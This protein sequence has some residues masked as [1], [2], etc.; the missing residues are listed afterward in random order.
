MVATLWSLVGMVGLVVAIV[1]LI[2]RHLDW[3][4]PANSKAAAAFG[5]SLT[6]LVLG[7]CTT[8]THPAHATRLEAVAVASATPS[9]EL[10]DPVTIMGGDPDEAQPTSTTAASTAGLS[11]AAALSPSSCRAG[12]PLRNVYHPYRLQVVARCST[13]SGTVRTVRREDDGDVHFDLQ[14]DP[15]YS[16]MLTAGNTDYQ[17]GF[18][19][20]E[21]VP[22]DEPGCVKGQPPRAATGTYDYGICTGA[23]ESTPAVGSHVYVTGPY[24]LDHVHD[25]AEIHPAWAISSSKPATTTAA[26]A[27]PRPSPAAPAPPVAAAGPAI[28]CQAGMSNAAPAQYSTTDVVVRTGASGASVSAT[29]HY[30]SKDTTNTGASGSTSIASIP[31]SISRATKGYTVVV[32]V[33]VSRSGRSASCSTSFT[34]T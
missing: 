30:K 4:R 22:A 13:V 31:F 26:A 14:L 17:H 1:A 27:P 11:P 32:D 3:A 7:G 23:D 5:V 9:P 25:W 6:V 12:D 10:S 21:L 29:A 24:V 2:R 28:S 16:R 8:P 18:L 15:A 19:V 34:P 33:T 20:V